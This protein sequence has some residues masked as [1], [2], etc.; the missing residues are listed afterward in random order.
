MPLA[1]QDNPLWS[2][3]LNNQSISG[4]S[5]TTNSTLLAGHFLGDVHIGESKNLNDVLKLL[6]RAKDAP[7]N[8]YNRQDEP[9]CLPNTRVDLLQE[10]YDWADGKDGQDE[11]C[12]FWL[13]GLA[14][15]GKSTISRTVARRYS[16]QKRLGASFF[17]ARGGGDVSHAGKFVTSLAVQLAD[18]VPFLQTH[19]CDAMRERSDIANLSLLDQWR[20][21]V[22]R[23]LK[24]VKSD[25]PPSP[26]SYLFIID[27]LDECDNDS[28]VRTILQLLG[29]AR[30]LSTVRLRVLLTSRP[31][32][33]IRHGIRAIP[34]DER[35]DFVLHDI[36]PAIINHDIALF[37]EHHLGMIGQE[38]TLGSEWPGD[39]A[40]KQL[41]IYASGLFI[42]AAT[43][44]RFIQDGEEFAEDRLEEILEGAGFEGTPEQHLDQIY[45]T[46]LQ[47]SIPTTLRLQEKA[48]KVTSISRKLVTHTLERLHAIL[49]VPKD[50]TGPLRLHHPSFRDFLLNKDRCGEYW[51]D[52]KKAHQLVATSCV[53]LMSQTLKKD[54]CD[55]YAPGTQ[56]SQ[57]ES[58][59]IEEYLPPEVQYACLYWAQHLQ[60]AE[61]QVRDG[62]EAH[63]FLQVHLLHW[64]E[65]LG[66]MGK[67]SE[68]VQAIL[69]L[70][71]H[72]LATKSLN[73]SAFIHDIKRFALYSRSIIE[74][75]PLQLYC[76]A[77]FFAPEKS[78][79]RRQFEDY[80]PTWIQMKPEVQADWSATLQTLEGHSS[81][82]TSVA[83]SPDGKQVVSGSEDHTVRLWDAA[84]GALKQTLEGHSQYVSSVAFSPDGTQVVSGSNDKTVRIW[85]A[86][87]GALQQTLEGHF[88]RVTSVAFSPDSKQ[89]VS[90]SED[91][92]VRLWDMA[93]G[94]LQQTLEDHFE[95]VTSVAFSPDS[96]RVVFG[97]RDKTIRL[98]DVGTRT[99]LP[100]PRHHSGMVYSVAFSPDGKQ[101]VS[102]SG[103]KTIHLWNAISGKYLRTLKGHSGS[104]CS[105]AFSPDGKQVVSGSDKTVQ[106]WDAISWQHLQTLEG[107]LKP[108]TSVAFSPD[109]KQVVSGS[110]DK[111]VRLWDAI[112]VQP[113]QTLEDRS[114]SVCSVAFSPDGKQVVSGSEDKTIHLWNAIS[115]KHLRTLKG[116][117][118]SVYSVAFSPDGKQVVS[119]SKDKTV[120]LWNAISGQH[121]QKLGAHLSTVRS[122]AFSPDGK[123]VVSGSYKGTICLWDAISRQ[124]L[125]TLEGHLK[126][127]TSVAFSPDGKQV[128]SS[129]ED[130]TVRLWNAATGT[131]QEPLDGHS[132][133]VSSMAFSPDGKLL[134]HLQVHN[135]WLA[136]DSIN[137]LWLPTD[138][139]PT[140]EAVWDKAVILGHTSGRISFL[141]I[142]K[143]P[144]SV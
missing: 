83:F 43:A 61:S 29:E 16:E 45:I 68:G 120:Q 41:V 76:S 8:A 132:R 78:I 48:S 113:L 24:L 20:E 127:V 140:C 99:T 104:V 130:K 89:I 44:C 17:F 35:Q 21:L 82:V 46:V 27:A 122:V 94:A 123:R 18:A 136:E 143:G 142:Q 97:S 108:V 47:T 77:L 37:L 131:L 111:T 114:G 139:R 74:K 23:P 90:G 60:K 28:H 49:G 144:K 15:T 85:D 63:R 91:N 96:K 102:G 53:Q 100:I 42:W 55:I 137:I 38:W 3:Q 19:I 98:W 4:L 5:A 124:H 9:A 101:V 2:S 121:P 133:G 54:I 81:S 135:Q 50:V 26:S 93:T 72:I 36:Q 25:K 73:L 62:D 1:R 110:Y 6:P 12:I 95:R 141:H 115:G 58:S 112:S 69:S 57:V 80:I 40:L 39:K 79:V 92:T 117:S 118:G 103:D 116:H 66:W 33:P 128:V 11:R 70:E 106:L 51:V 52:E 107:H 105:V 67:T 134:P 59:R 109:G 56:A 75:A 119:G 71:G 64:L 87:T 32:V 84:T 65:A 31:E 22:I 14:G 138:Y 86:A 34:Q 7:F 126:P 129:S 88:K 30:S 13:S 125:Q 10:I